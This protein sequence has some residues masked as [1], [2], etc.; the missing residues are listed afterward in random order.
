MRTYGTPVVWRNAFSTNILFLTGQK[1]TFAYPVRD[2]ILVE[3]S[4]SPFLPCPV[5]DK[6]Y[7][8]PA[9]TRSNRGSGE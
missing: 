6:I 5:R 8:S 3:N 7:I 2:I 4:A 9:A 1:T